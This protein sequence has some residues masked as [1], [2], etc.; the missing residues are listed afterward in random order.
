L[1]LVGCLIR[2]NVHWLDKYNITYKL[3]GTVHTVSSMTVLYFVQFELKYKA[4]G[5]EKHPTRGISGF[6]REVD[7]KRAL[8][9]H[10]PA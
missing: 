2:N 1:R 4:Q 6:R 3:H 10:Y 8:L 9:D 5:L 7:E